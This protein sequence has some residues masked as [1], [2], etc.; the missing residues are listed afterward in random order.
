MKFEKVDLEVV[1]LTV[2]DVITESTDN[3][4]GSYDCNGYVPGITIF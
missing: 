2:A 3:N 1:K 4:C